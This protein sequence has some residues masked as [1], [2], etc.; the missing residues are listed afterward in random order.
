MRRFWK[1]RADVERLGDDSQKFSSTLIPNP[2]RR[3]EGPSLFRHGND[4]ELASPGD[5][6][7]R[8]FRTPHHADAAVVRPNGQVVVLLITPGC[9]RFGCPVNLGSG[10]YLSS[11]TLY[12]TNGTRNVAAS[13]VSA[14]ERV[15]P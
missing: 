14:G 5:T 15:L 2:P 6:C 11:G 1:R 9:R 7:L 13:S 4:A 12:S 10:S 8:H 3:S